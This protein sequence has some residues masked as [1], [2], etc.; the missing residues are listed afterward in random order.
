MSIYLEVCKSIKTRS[1]WY[2]N[3]QFLGSGGNSVTYLVFST[4]GATKG[5]LYA[6]KIFK[7][8]YSPERIESF[9]DEIKFLE[10]CNHPAIMRIFDSGIY[11]NNQ[12]VDYPFVVAEYLPNTLFEVIRRNAV[13]IPEK[14]SYA[15]QLLSALKYL[16]E[17]DEPVVHRDIKPQNI[18]IKG[19]SCVLGDFG[20]MKKLDRNTEQ[21]REIFR[22][23]IGPG[24]PY[25]YRTP[26][27]IAY[28]R[29]E[30]ELSV[31]SDIFQ[32]GLV[33][34]E[35]FTGRNP[36]IKPNDNL[37]PFEM[38]PLKS[39]PGGLGPPIGNVLA[40]MLNLN[41]NDIN[42]IDFIMDN[43]QGLFESAVKR[44]HRLNG[45]IF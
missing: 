27:L 7:R 11:T 12:G 10:E 30:S 1:T 32:L 3:I 14:I 31:K 44:A 36:A 4:S 6:L 29:N 25:Y 23:S 26:N 35:L 43:W 22:E 5:N 40:Q 28:V 13:S 2:R 41:W 45:K 16:E 9:F 39:V 18:F 24:M 34:A 42:D 15:L 17:L 21:D 33:L 37:D 8:I 20:L 38:E 19:R